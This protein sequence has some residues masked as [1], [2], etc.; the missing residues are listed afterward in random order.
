M[1]MKAS[2]IVCAVVVMASMAWAAAFDDAERSAVRKS[3]AMAGERLK[4][5]AALSG[6]A[7]TL[8]PV[9]GDRDGYCEGLLVDEFVKAG[10]DCVISNDDKK[11]ER[12]KRILKEIAWDERQTTLKSIDPRTAD[13]LGHLKSTQ[14]LVEARVDIVRRGRKRR[15]VAELHVLAYAVSTKQYVWTARVAADDAGRGWPSPEDFNVKVGFKGREDAKGISAISASAVRNAVAGY[16]YRVDA[17][18]KGDLSLSAEFTREAFDQSGG[19]FVFNGTA[20]VRLASISGDG[21]LYEKTFTARGGR[22]LG[23]AA[24]ERRLADALDAQILKWLEDTLAPRVFFA[25][26]PDFAEQAVR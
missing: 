24:A 25:K 6:K 2:G 14:I 15:P 12:F 7:I 17:E 16:G 20:N 26:H 1:K 9:K 19:Y 4:S 3:A 22:A 5:A 8:L 18:G 21:V 13:E 23:E 11:D 10:K